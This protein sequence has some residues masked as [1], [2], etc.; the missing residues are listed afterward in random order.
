[1]TRTSS[2][3]L[4]VYLVC[5]GSVLA[6]KYGCKHDELL[7]EDVFGRE[8]C[9][10]EE[11]AVYQAGLSMSLSMSMSMSMSFDYEGRH[12]S[13]SGADSLQPVSFDSIVPSS[14]PVTEVTTPPTVKS[15]DGAVDVIVREV[16]VEKEKAVNADTLDGRKNGDSGHPGIFIVLSIAI[17]TVVVVAVARKIGQVRGRIA[18]NA[19]SSHVTMARTESGSV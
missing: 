10:Y 19:A 3:L 6:S 7:V 1:M 4:Y 14:A 11:L 15:G 18:K 17:G 13:S 16:V 2:A 9:A 8:G 12:V 5:V